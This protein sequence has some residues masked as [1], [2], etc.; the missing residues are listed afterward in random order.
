MHNYGKKMNIVWWSSSVSWS[1]T[2]RVVERSKR[3][4]FDFLYIW[5]NMKAWTVSCHPCIPLLQHCCWYDLFNSTKFSTCKSGQ[6][7]CEEKPCPSTCSVVGFQ[8]FTTFD[9]FRYTYQGGNCE[10]YL[11]KVRSY[12]TAFYTSGFIHEYRCNLNFEPNWLM[13]KGSTFVS[14]DLIGLTAK[15]RTYTGHYMQNFNNKLFQPIDLDFWSY[16]LI[17]HTPKYESISGEGQ[18]FHEMAL[19]SLILK[20]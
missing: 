10:H 6:W 12:K 13:N 14:V 5:M 9:G 11:V 1:S 7:E 8:H 4:D 20:H 2:K 18:F 15:A 17:I 16:D 19:N 3:L